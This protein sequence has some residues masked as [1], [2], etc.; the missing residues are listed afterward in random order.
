[1]TNNKKQLEPGQAIGDYGIKYI[2]DGERKQVSWMK[3]DVRTYILQ[4]HCGAEFQR[5]QIGKFWNG[6]AQSCGCT[7]RKRAAEKITKHGHTAGAHGNTKAWSPE[8]AAWARAKDRA[9]NTNG[10]RAKDYVD[11][12]IGM[13]QEYQ[14]SFEAFLQE[15]GHKPEG[16]YSLDRIDNEKGYIKGNMQWSIRSRQ[17]RNRRNTTMLSYKGAEIS[18][19][20]FLDIFSFEIDYR[21]L[22]WRVTKYKATGEDLLRIYNGTEK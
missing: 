19:M 21:S 15:V 10:E 14:D 5:E 20:D 9:T 17:Q 2:R 18:L 6:K 1:M 11:R 7:S 4:C 8:Y 13:D 16:D 12:G 3:Y 22:A